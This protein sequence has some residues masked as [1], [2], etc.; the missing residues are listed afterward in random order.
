MNRKQYAIAGIF[1]LIAFW[2]GRTICL[3]GDLGGEVEKLRAAVEILIRRIEEQDQ[4]IVAL[5]NALKALSSSGSESLATTDKATKQAAG[6]LEGWKDPANWARIRDGMSQSQVR[7]ILGS[8][9]SIQDSRWYYEGDVPG[10]GTVSGNIFWLSHR[11]LVVYV[12][13]F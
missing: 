1:S 11:V 4:R 3:A 9:S 7:A 6:S 13:V 10:S 5:E 8:P 12:P 2:G